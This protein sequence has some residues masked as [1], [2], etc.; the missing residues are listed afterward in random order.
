MRVK[1][2]GI[3]R[4]EDA[5]AVAEAGADALGLVFYGP[6]PRALDPE[7]AQRIAAEAGP[8]LT[9]VALF[10]NPAVEEV[11]KVLR[12]V[13]PHLLQFHGDEPPDFCARFDRPYLKAI[14][15]RQETDIATAVEGF[16]SAAGFIFDAWHKDLFGGTGQTFDWTKIRGFNKGKVVLAGGLTAENVAEAVTATRPYGVDVSGGVEQSPGV[17]DAAKIVRFVEHARKAAHE[18]MERPEN[19]ISYQ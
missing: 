10:V 12:Q 5:R 11:E 18:A 15:V 19:T 17:K 1:I 2:C 8:F 16:E 13:K 6:S 3:R 14:R 4:V 9:T 7:T